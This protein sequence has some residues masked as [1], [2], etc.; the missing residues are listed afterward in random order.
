MRALT[1]HVSALND[2]EYDTY[3]DALNDL[4]NDGKVALTSDEYYD[5]V[6]VGVREVR[7]WLRGRFPTVSIADVDSVSL[8]NPADVVVVIT[9]P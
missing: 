8:S 5:K 7:A 2:A 6:K 1:L 4:T 3:T 9:I